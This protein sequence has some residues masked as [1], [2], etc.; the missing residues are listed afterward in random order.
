MTIKGL[1]KLDQF[2]SP[3]E[4]LTLQTLERVIDNKPDSYDKLDFYK[5]LKTQLLKEPFYQSRKELPI[6]IKIKELESKLSEL[7]TK[8]GVL[9]DN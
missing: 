1:D 5:F 3:V 9:N 8:K 7:N 6:D 2:L 4:L